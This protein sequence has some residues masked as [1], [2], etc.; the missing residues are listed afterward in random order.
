[1]NKPIKPTPA[2]C[3]LE[4][5]HAFR[6]TWD[7]VGMDILDITEAETGGKLTVRSTVVDVLI[8]QM[9]NHEPWKE[10]TEEARDY[11]N[12]LAMDEMTQI[13]QDA[14]PFEYYGL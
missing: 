14:M 10:L 6:Q 2:T 5:Q 4:L 12:K 9:K 11:W 3:E 1:M 8:D 7:I 13:G